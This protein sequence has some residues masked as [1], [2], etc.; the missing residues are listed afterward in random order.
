MSAMRLVSFSARSN[1]ASNNVTAASE[2]WDI[3]SRIRFKEKE[4]DWLGL[5]SFGAKINLKAIRVRATARTEFRR[6][7]DL[8]PPVSECQIFICWLEGAGR[9]SQK[10]QR[11]MQPERPFLGTTRLTFSTSRT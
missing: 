10:G 5:V 6:R 1:S 2:Y 3:Q 4:E 9:E 7:M 11:R 8:T